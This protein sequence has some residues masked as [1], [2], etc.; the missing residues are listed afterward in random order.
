[1]AALFGLAVGYRVLSYCVLKLRI[2]I[3]TSL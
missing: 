3:E 2:R 1:V